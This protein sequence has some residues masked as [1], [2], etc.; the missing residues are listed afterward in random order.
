MLWR[1]YHRAVTQKH[2]ASFWKIEPPK[3][4]GKMIAFV[5]A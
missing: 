5:A 3:A 4:D 1:H 2:A